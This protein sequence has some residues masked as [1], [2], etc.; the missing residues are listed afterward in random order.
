MARP[1]AQNLAKKA[2]GGDEDATHT[3]ILFGPKTRKDADPKAF[4]SKVASDDSYADEHFPQD[5]DDPSVMGGYDETP[6]PG[7]DDESAEKSVTDEHPEQRI[8]AI[9]KVLDEAGVK[10]PDLAQ[11]ICDALDALNAKGE[12]PAQPPM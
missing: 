6:V 5:I 2:A 9:Q 4:A 7:A 8:A 1:V 3:L 11:K 10:M 12:E